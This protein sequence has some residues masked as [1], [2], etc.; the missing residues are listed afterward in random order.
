[1]NFLTSRTPRERLLIFTAAFLLFLFPAWQFGARP[2]LESKS[3]AH[4]ARQ[5]A[6]RNLDIVQRGLPKISPSSVAR[7]KLP[8]DRSAVLSAARGANVAI[9]R[10]QPGADQALQVWFEDA[11]APDIYRVLAEINTAYA[12][13]INRVQ[14]TRRDTGRVSAQITFAPQ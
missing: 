6:V 12:V 8:F 9:S 4:K 13:S 2:V 7:D 14:I 3:S 11:D 10:V 1:M 5:V